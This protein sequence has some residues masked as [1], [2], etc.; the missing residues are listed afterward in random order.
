M[1]DCRYVELFRERQQRDL[2]RLI[3]LGYTF[4]PCPRVIDFIEQYCRHW[5]GEWAGQLLELE[6]WQRERLGII[7]GWYRPDGLRRFRTAYNEEP[8]KNG[9]TTEAAGVGNYLMIA[10]DEPGAEIFSIA[11]KEDQARLVFEDAKMMV[12]QSPDLSRFVEPLKKSLVV[13]RSNSFFKPLGA[14]SKTQDGLNVH[15]NICDEMHAHRDRHLYDVM[16]TGQ[17]SR[18]QPMNYII[19]TAGVYDPTSIG[20]QMHD[21]AVQILEGTIEDDTFFAYIVGADKDDDWTDPVVWA[22]ANPNLGVSVKR[23]SLEADQVLAANQP[24]FLNT[25]LRYHLNIWTNQVD[26]WIPPDV[27]TACAEPTG[28]PTGPC[29]GAID[30]GATR[31]LTAFVVVWPETWDVKAWFWLPED[32]VRDRSKNEGVYY[33]QWVRA[34][35]IDLLPGVTTD[36]SIVEDRIAKIA[37]SLLIEEIGF[38]P[39][40][41]TQMSQN[42]EQQHG[43]QMIEMRQIP[44]VLSEPSIRFEELVFSGQLRHGDNP[45]LS[46]MAGNVATY[47]D[48]NGNMK[49]DKKRSREKI[50][51]IVALIMAIG[52]ASVGVEQGSPEIWAIA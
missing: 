16:I 33:D 17:G 21:Y 2:E 36:L 40:R 35:L 38:D 12:K 13:E 26:R 1:N 8:R 18:R 20:W 46:W 41:A 14:D 42:L 51:G 23:E 52:R 30:L 24:S 50:D 7:F 5:K 29:Y 11:T 22:K 47:E 43:F 6:P 27:W 34:G 3:P 28:A 32:T 10:D 45:V 31:D 39:W 25:F 19:T 44:S 9:K 37:S 4:D 15:G 48:S 49:P